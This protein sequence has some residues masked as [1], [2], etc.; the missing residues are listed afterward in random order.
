MEHESEA[1]QSHIEDLFG[2]SLR[3]VW[4]SRSKVEVTRDKNALCTPIGSDGMECS[5][6]K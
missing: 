6:C 5:H 3:R 1:C 4:M 2:P